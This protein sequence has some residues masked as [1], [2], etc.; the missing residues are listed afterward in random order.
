MRVHFPNGEHAD[1]ALHQ[2]ELSF[3]AGGMNDVRPAIAGLLERHATLRND[4]IRGLELN[5]LSAD[6]KVF[7]NGRSV[8]GRALVRLGDLVFF[9]PLR[10]LLKPDSDYR[11][12]PPEAA[13]PE[14][15]GNETSLHFVPPRAMLRA[16]S[17]PLFGKLIVLRARTV[18]GRGSDCDLVLNEPEMS[19]RHA[20][21]ENTPKG[22]YLRDMGSANG[23]FVNGVAVRDTVLKNGDQIAFDLNRFLVEAPGAGVTDVQTDPQ[24]IQL[25][26]SAD[27]N[28][29]GVT[30]RIQA[31]PAA[32]TNQSAKSD[33]PRAVSWILILTSLVTLAALAAF[34]Y[35]QFQKR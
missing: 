24:A 1:V 8:R 32:Q 31:N 3:G 6:A 7:V 26:A 12:K 35:L 4:A 18:I 34:L 29:T 27:S 19:R 25:P 5:V 14:Q 15:T 17:G 10:T 11:E 13:M 9:G 28:R 22:L 16:V 21:I 20:M 33:P 2:G 30:P 23:T